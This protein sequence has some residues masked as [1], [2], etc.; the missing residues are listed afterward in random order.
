MEPLAAEGTVE[1]SQIILK[2][3]SPYYYRHVNF[4]IDDGR[5]DL[6]SR[7]QYQKAGNESDVG[8]SEL[9]ADMNSLRLRKLGE[10][11]DFLKVPVI[12]VKNLSADLTKKQVNID[13][14]SSRGGF[15]LG[16]RYR[17]G[18]L[19]FATLLKVSEQVRPVK[20]GKTAGVRKIAAEKPWA[21][22]VNKFLWEKYT[23]RFDDRMLQDPVIF[24]MRDVRV[25]GS[26]ISTLKNAKGPI[27][28]RMKVEDKGSVLGNGTV[29]IEPVS[30]NLKLITKN[31]PIMPLQSYITD[32][33]NVFITDGM[34][35]SDGSLSFSQPRK[36]APLFRY[37]G[38]LTI[39]QF[40]T[41]D[42]NNAEDFL[43]WDSLHFSKMDIRHAPLSVNI[44]D[45]A[46]TDFYSRFVINADGSLNVQNII[47]KEEKK[48]AADVEAGKTVPEAVKEAPA[49]NAKP[50]KRVENALPDL[51]KD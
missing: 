12:S 30:V 51:S 50:E 3:Y 39:N 2:K 35:S 47:A 13:D 38:S 27:S 31:M 36:G 42:K 32:R 28:L 22:T 5:L 25:K 19:I 9:Q 8:I 14:M 37:T 20:G 26:N 21:V 15:I 1:A 18:G 49:V 46:L 4:S 17:V 7:Y 10:K 33:I 6:R 34:V 48:G 41:I 44:S 11:E 43:K 29:T 24:T 45:V 40:A 23:I 16:K